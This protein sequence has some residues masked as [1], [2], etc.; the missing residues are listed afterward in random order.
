MKVPI[1]E[2]SLTMRP[3]EMVRSCTKMQA[4]M[5]ECGPKVKHMAQVFIV[6]Q[7]ALTIKENFSLI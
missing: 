4:C 5:R 2:N 6:T 7:M 1:T 3:A